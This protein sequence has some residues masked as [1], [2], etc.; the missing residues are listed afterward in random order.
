MMSDSRATAIVGIVGSDTAIQA[1]PIPSLP[2]G[3]AQHG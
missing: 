3:I 1:A 2:S